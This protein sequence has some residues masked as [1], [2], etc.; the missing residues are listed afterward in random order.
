MTKLIFELNS[1]EDCY[2]VFIAIRFL[3]K[4]SNKIKKK[5]YVFYSKNRNYAKTAGNRHTE[6]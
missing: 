6:C 3:N 2:Y 5:E 1:I 4:N